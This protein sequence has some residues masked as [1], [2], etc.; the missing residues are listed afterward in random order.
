MNTVTAQPAPTIERLL[1]RLLTVSVIL[2]ACITLLGAGLHLA[3][4]GAEKPPDLTT[5][6]GQPERLTNPPSVLADAAAFDPG[7]V[8]QLGIIL[9]I[10]TPVARV[11]FSLVL[12]AVRRDRLYTVV[13][14]IV[15]AGL[16][17]GLL[18]VAD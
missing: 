11:A 17:L 7:A 1:S 6:A 18:G 15:L 4:H 16:A 2:S 12:F 9:L 8:M 14:L 13:T 5:F 3:H 10:A